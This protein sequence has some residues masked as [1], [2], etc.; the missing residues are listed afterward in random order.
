MTT[1]YE[2]SSQHVELIANK[3][4]ALEKRQVEAEDQLFA[5]ISRDYRSGALDLVDLVAVHRSLR[6]YLRPGYSKRW[7]GAGLPSVNR[8]NTYVDLRHRFVMNGPGGN[9]WVGEY[10]IGAE[11]PRP[12]YG[13]SVVYVLYGSD[14]KP[15]YVGSTSAFIP[16]VNT[17]A[18]DG[19]KFVA[20]MAV[21]C[22][23]REHAYELEVKLLR[24]SMP[25]L[26]R[27]VG[28]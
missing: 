18:R 10:P 20:W 23:D 24:Q 21:P 13:V 2:A 1:S 22:R 16:R 4:K 26:N 15:V 19:K 7:H 25:P 17:H 28:R 14:N 5:S 3:I 12:D 11:E 9:S 27:R 6:V 8:L